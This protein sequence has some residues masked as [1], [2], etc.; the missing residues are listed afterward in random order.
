MLMMNH[1]ILIEE[2][3]AQL[4]KSRVTLES[5]AS[6]ASHA[7]RS[8]RHAHARRGVSRIL[9]ALNDHALAGHHERRYRRGVGE[10]G[11]DNLERVDDATRNH[12]AI[13]TGGGVVAPVVVVVAEHLLDDNTALHAS[14]VGDGL[15]GHLDCR[16]D[17]LHTNLLVEVGH[18]SLQLGE[19][20]GCLEQRCTTTRDNTLVNRRFGGIERINDA[21]LLLANLNLGGA[22]NLEYR[23]TARE[24]RESLLHLLPVVVRG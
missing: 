24:L 22:A 18:R 13:L 8:R 3:A 19:R 16:L 11:P 20:L 6:H 14:V 1:R 12:V 21:I 17:D 10:G 4:R 2:F 5:H 7:S 23:D 15:H 9:L